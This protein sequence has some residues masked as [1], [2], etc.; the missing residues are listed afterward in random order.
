MNPNVIELLPSVV[1][2]E[3]HTELNSLTKVR[4]RTYNRITNPKQLVR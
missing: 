2:S 3:I 1:I 4:Q